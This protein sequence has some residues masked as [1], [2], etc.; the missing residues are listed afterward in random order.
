M[1]ANDVGRV[2]REEVEAARSQHRGGLHGG[3]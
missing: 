1:D 2:T 3:F